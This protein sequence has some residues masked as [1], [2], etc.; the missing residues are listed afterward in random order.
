M[1]LE[2]HI[3]SGIQA[4]FKEERSRHNTQGEGGSS[5]KDTVVDCARD[6]HFE[7]WNQSDQ[8]SSLETTPERSP[9][10]M[11]VSVLRCD[12]RIPK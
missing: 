3:S 1:P 4:S 2:D 10:E 6:T 11:P 5:P 12:V 8:L 9:I 7:A